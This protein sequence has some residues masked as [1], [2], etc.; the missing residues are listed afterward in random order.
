MNGKNIKLAIKE[1]AKKEYPDDYDMQEYEYN[2]QLE[3]YLFMKSVDELKIKQFAIKEYPDDYDMQQDEY[4]RQLEAY[5]F[6][7][8][9]DDL[10][11]KQFAIKEYPDDYD[12][13]Q[14]VYEL[15]CAAKKRMSK[16]GND[17]KKEQ[18]ILEYPNDYDMQIY[19][20]E[21]LGQESVNE[22]IDFKAPELIP[23]EKAKKND[24]EPTI[25]KVV[26]RW[27]IEN[28]NKNTNEPN[29]IITTLPGEWS[30]ETVLE[31]QRQVYPYDIIRSRGKFNMNKAKYGNNG[32][33]IMPWC[34]YNR[35][36]AIFE[37]IVT[38]A[39]LIGFAIWITK[40]AQFL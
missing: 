36:L 31:W 14:D 37:I 28:P 38:I 5:L 21:E 30:E 33:Q 40:L 32:E 12:M 23:F 11:I 3:A 6:M 18:A 7:K 2:K 17:E 9:V 19:A 20:Y 27:I 24:P 4:N 8:S 25:N 39:V 16:L 35:I 15:Q 1:F 34:T 13:Q 10:K 26:L 29:K 22:K